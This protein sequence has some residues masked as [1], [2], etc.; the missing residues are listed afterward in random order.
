LLATRVPAA[1]GETT[2][3]KIATDLQPLRSLVIPVKGRPLRGKLTLANPSAQAVEGTLAFDGIPADAIWDAGSGEATV[4]LGS[5]GSDRLS[6]V[7]IEPGSFALIQLSAG[8][9]AVSKGTLTTV[10]SS[11]GQPDRQS[12]W[13]FDPAEAG[14]STAVI[15]AGEFKSNPFYSVP[16]YHHYMQPEDSRLPANFRITTSSPARVELY[17]AEDHP[18]SVDANGDGSLGES[19][20]SLFADTDNDGAADLPAVAGETSFRIQVYPSGNIPAD[21]LK[22]KLENKLDGRWIAVAEDRILP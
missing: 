16:I 10:W 4:T 20:D 15:E 8:P 6:K 13:T 2:P 21:G 18:V 19:G 22:V 12:V 3:P 11:P 7:R 1:A 5:A 14:V 17:D 9:D